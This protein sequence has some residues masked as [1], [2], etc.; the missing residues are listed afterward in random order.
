MSDSDDNGGYQ[1]PLPKRRASVI[2]VLAAAK[3]KLNKKSKQAIMIAKGKARELA[4]MGRSQPKSKKKRGQ[5]IQ[6]VRDPELD[7][8][9]RANIDARQAD[10]VKR[11]EEEEANQ[12]GADEYAAGQA[13]CRACLKPAEKR[14]CCEKWYCN[15]CYYKSTQCPNCGFL[16]QERH[17]G[18]AEDT[19][20]E[21]LTATLLV[22]AVWVGGFGTL[23]VGAGMH[24][25]T[26]PTTMHGLTCAGF[27]PRCQPGCIEHQGDLDGG[28]PPL[29][30]WRTC[31]RDSVVKFRNPVCV[32]D[33]SLYE[34]SNKKY[35]YDFCTGGR[36]VG[37]RAA[38]IDPAL[39]VFEDDM[40]D[41]GNEKGSYAYRWHLASARWQSVVNG[42]TTGECGAL[43]AKNLPADLKTT[44]PPDEAKPLGM[45]TLQFYGDFER[46]V[47]T[48]PLDVTHGGRLDFWFK[49][50]KGH[51]PRCNVQY[52]GP[53][54]L[55]YS[56]NGGG[57]WTSWQTFNRVLY[58]SKGLN[59]FTKP[60]PPAAST[61]ATLFRWKQEDFSKL[62]DHWALDDVRVYR[63]AR[64]P[65]QETEGHAGDVVA[66]R[67]FLQRARCCLDSY[68]CITVGNK[69]KWNNETCGDLINVPD[70]DHGMFRGGLADNLKGR[71]LYAVLAMCAWLLRQSYNV[72]LYMLTHSG[73]P[74]R[75]VLLWVPVFEFVA[76]MKRKLTSW[77]LQQGDEMRQR[78]AAADRAIGVAGR[79]ALFKGKMMK[80]IGKER[81]H[82]TH[83]EHTRFD[84]KFNSRVDSSWQWFF[85]VVV[86]ISLL[87][88]FGSLLFTELPTHRESVRVGLYLPVGLR[89]GRFRPRS[90]EAEC[91]AHQY[92]DKCTAGD[93]AT[94]DHICLWNYDSGTC[95]LIEEIKKRVRRPVPT[96]YEV[97][98]AL[99]AFVAMFIDC[100]V[101]WNVAQHTICTS[102][103]GA[104][105]YSFNGRTNKMK[106]DNCGFGK[107]QNIDLADIQE[108]Q[109]YPLS[110]AKIM[111]F[112]MLF[113]TMPHMSILLLCH[114]KTLGVL[115]G[116]IALARCLFGPLIAIKAFWVSEYL[117]TSVLVCNPQYDYMR[118]EF[119][120]AIFR[121]YTFVIAAVWGLVG[122]PV[123]VGLLWIF[124]IDFVPNVAIMSCAWAFFGA[125]AA[126]IQGIPAYPCLFL[127]A[128]DV[129]Y[130][131]RYT[132]QQE[133]KGYCCHTM[134]SKIYQNEAMLMCY[135]ENQPRF[136]D[137]L[138]GIAPD[139]EDVKDMR[140]KKIFEYSS[141]EDES[142][143]GQVE[144]EDA[145]AAAQRARDEYMSLVS[146]HMDAGDINAG[147]AGGGARAPD[148]V[149]GAPRQP[150]RGALKAFSS[151][152]GGG[153]SEE[154]KG[155][156]RL[157][158]GADESSEFLHPSLLGGLRNSFKLQKGGAADKSPQPHTASWKANRNHRQK[159]SSPNM[160]PLAGSPAGSVTEI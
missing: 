59:F 84:A 112:Q 99:I 51:Y 149:L 52:D 30:D 131:V 34:R 156:D 65:F 106:I 60:L 16:V 102:K 66:G 54:T 45:F 141:E 31:T 151:G 9:L 40:N 138:R 36:G 15:D 145:I 119:A 120:N 118:I 132:K 12:V 155:G 47:T 135:V 5:A 126:A 104:P 142:D 115:I 77:A 38:K 63:T 158:F 28:L 82:D 125:C 113:I 136:N 107:D 57:N 110:S 58:R 19:S 53:V 91:N 39:I 124:D 23:I 26:L 10:V 143:E 43:D 1:H 27:M 55:A 18:D 150:D 122:W 116:L 92:Q 14:H 56:T 85:L 68:G 137:L 22:A 33:R 79:V 105:S 48:M 44:L 90:L 32:V 24:Y 89:A 94:G 41:A 62:R 109:Q 74:P 35:G 81:G 152:G 71:E 93:P 111:G 121:P 154:H 11:E 64:E 146:A 100:A 7:A 3:G 140:D 69:L 139:M 95:T 72:L 144:G 117:I 128:I 98:Y 134:W 49:Y 127:T 6:L 108:I 159:G 17:L 75:Y 46:H 88:V 42:A 101:A 147:G 157:G 50:S 4:E 97:P 73:E 103:R 87:S 70:P 78:H 148:P 133:L 80:S 29:R 8:Q 130:Y 21:K 86:T 96:V 37:G 114:D 123:S 83:D 76:K 153:F 20:R 67:A 25:T 13:N 61:G 160:Q 2:E 129:G